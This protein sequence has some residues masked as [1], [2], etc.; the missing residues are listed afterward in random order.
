MTTAS[1]ASEGTGSGL[2][3]R[4]THRE[5]YPVYVG[6]AL[7]AVLPAVLADARAA[8]GSG[9]VHVI[10]DAV[11]AGHYLERVTVIAGRA[12]FPVS[13][14]VLPA[15][16][17]AKDSTVLPV[18][19][20]QMRASGTDRRTL[21]LAVG[22]G[23]V[24]DIATLA[25]ATYMRGLPC[26]LVPTTLIAQ[27]DAATG[28]KGGADFEGVKNLIGAFY[29]PAAVIID[30]ALLATLDDRQVSRGL[31]EVVKVAVIGDRVLFE[32]LE[33]AAVITPAV[34]GEAI[35]RAVGG[36]LDLLAADP[37]ERGSLARALNYGHTLGHAVEAASGFTVHHGEAVAMGMTTAVA[38]GIATG[39]CAAADMDRIARLLARYRL[40]VTIPAPLR[41]GT[42]EATGDIRRVR[43]GQLN[44]VVPAGI[45]AYAIIPDIT[46]AQYQQAVTV[47][48][49]WESATSG[50]D[51]EERGRAVRC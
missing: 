7:D 21:V 25:A 12:G 17:N 38:I 9:R 49:Q 15:G 37:L 1:L 43:N 27:A 41:A 44:L 23:T 39:D 42:W 24:C 45:G 4:L 3:V 50:T 33:E 31:A 26:A 20:H 34:L 10:T 6:Q 40:P 35:R 36:K 46:R 11:V 22:G 47:T 28:G 5:S 48:E 29:H 16:E 18:I 8:R 13:V 32:M 19:W 14:H 30:P 51:Q 2:V